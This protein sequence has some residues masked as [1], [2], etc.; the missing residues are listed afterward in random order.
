MSV[1]RLSFLIPRGSENGFSPVQSHQAKQTLESPANLGYAFTFPLGFFDSQFIAVDFASDH[2]G[3]SI[4]FRSSQR[5]HFKKAWM[6]IHDESRMFPSRRPTQ[7]RRQGRI[8]ASRR[9]CKRSLRIESLDARLLFAANGSHLLADV[10]EGASGS[11]PRDFVQSRNDIYFLADSSPAASDLWTTD[12]IHQTNLV[13]QQTST[14]NVYLR[15]LFDHQDKLVFLKSEFAAGTGGYGLELWS[16]QGTPESTLLVRD[17]GVNNTQIAAEPDIK[18]APYFG[19]AGDKLIASI[20]GRNS[21]GRELWVSDLTNV[22]TSM[23]TDI[24]PGAPS[25]VPNSWIALNDKVYFSATSESKGEEL[26]VSDGVTIELV[27]DFMP[28]TQGSY[29]SGMLVAEGSLFFATHD[30]GSDGLYSSDDHLKWW[31]LEDPVDRK[32]VV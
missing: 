13:S 28:G 11:S 26:W 2:F 14:G 10:A 16:S 19:S 6:M 15:G 32:S 12:G 8:N 9:R 7:Q 18:Q 25:S 23:L 1:A 21:R 31:R 3:T 24:D 30:V 27:Q 29:P 22:G 5:S 4:V 20:D 17:F